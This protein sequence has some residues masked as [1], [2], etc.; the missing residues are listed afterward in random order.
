MF[1]LPIFLFFLFKSILS[2]FSICRSLI[3]KNCKNPKK[4]ENR[5]NH[6]SLNPALNCPKLWYQEFRRLRMA[7]IFLFRFK[8]HNYS[9]IITHWLLSWSLLMSFNLSNEGLKWSLDMI[10]VV[11]VQYLCNGPQKTTWPKQNLSCYRKLVIQGHLTSSR[12]QF[13]PSS[14]WTDYLFFFKFFPISVTFWNHAVLKRS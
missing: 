6:K 12:Y 1:N 8:N 11:H 4:D 14:F 5:K 2:F 3:Y 7:S 10:R 13:M 9:V